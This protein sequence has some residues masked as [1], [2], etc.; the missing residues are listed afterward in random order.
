MFYIVSH[1]RRGLAL[2]LVGALCLAPLPAGAEEPPPS[3][4]D[5]MT[6]LTTEVANELFA[7]FPDSLAKRPVVLKG[8]TVNEHYQFLNS[9]LTR[10]LTGRG[11]TVYPNAAPTDG[12]RTVT[13]Q[14]QAIEFDLA[15]TKV[16]RSWLIGGKK[17]LRE[18]D[19]TLL[20]TLFAD[21]GSVAWTGQAQRDHDDE[22]RHSDL[23][24]IEEGNYQFLHPELPGGG[25]G[26]YAEPVLVTGIVVGLIYLF[27][28]NQ[29]DS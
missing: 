6:N 5:L 8:F 17:V 15:Y 26:K 20:G 10:L 7:E 28:S 18:A 4:L 16:Y 19:V 9:V 24:D 1:C 13:F 23:D 27:F 21:G 22:F 12:T 25:W 2:A 3:N 11:I 14:Y 29:S